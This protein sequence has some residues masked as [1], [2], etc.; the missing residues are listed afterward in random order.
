M[1]PGWPSSMTIPDMTEKDVFNILMKQE[2][3]RFTPGEKFEYCNAGYS[4][5]GMIIEK[6]SGES[7][8][9]FMTANIFK[10]LGMNQTSVNEISHP[11]KTRAI[12]YTMYGTD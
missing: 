11:D 4:L 7:L 12:G 2:S 8:N 1:C 3:L 6:I 9:E 5:L 10:P